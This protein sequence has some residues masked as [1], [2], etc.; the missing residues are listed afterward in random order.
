MGA[1]VFLLIM[2]S[3]KYLQKTNLRGSLQS[4][5]LFSEQGFER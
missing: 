4:F 1:N 2:K 5:A 3:I